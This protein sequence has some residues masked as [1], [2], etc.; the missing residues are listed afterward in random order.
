MSAKAL[1]K[2]ASSGPGRKSG[3]KLEL[4]RE[5]SLRF[6]S[7]LTGLVSSPSLEE[8]FS[9]KY[10]R[11]VLLSK[12]VDEK[13][14]PAS[15]LRR[16]AIVKWLGVEDRNRRTNLRL[17][18]T[19]PNFGF[20][21]G[22]ELL[23]RASR[24]I[25]RVIGREPPE[26]LLERGSF[27]G[28]ATTSVKRGLG[29]LASKFLGVRDVTPR[30]WKRLLPALSTFEG[31]AAYN[32][33]LD[34]PRYVR[35]NVLFTVPKSALIDRVACKEPDYNIFG[36]K[37]V[38]DYIRKR[39]RRRAGIDLNDQSRNRTLAR[40]GSRTGRLA[41]IDLS[42][43]SDSLTTGLV[44]LLLPHQW[45]TLLDDLRSPE[46][47]I[48]GEPHENEMF[49]SMGNGF[50]F[51]LE[52]LVFWA[53]AQEVRC[54]I[55]ATGPVSVYGDDIIVPTAC[56]GALIKVLSWVGF[57]ANLK[58][59]FLRGGFRESCGGHYYR[60]TD[61]TPFYLRR[62]VKDI[63][64]LIL[65]LNQLRRWL[66]L[67]GW[68]FAY[69][70]ERIVANCFVQFWRRWSRCV[71]AALH[72]GWDLSSRHQLVSAGPSRARLTRVPN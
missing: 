58:K 50:T 12:Y 59:T 1:A 54:A 36:Q 33:E 39:L 14:L 52:S 4:S 64:D 57:T 24:R 60:G 32:P 44:S 69:D 35:G 5:Q 62:P 8:D 6:H 43:A 9:L 18:E 3:R 34:K 28:G 68:D 2:F 42:S 61:V 51:E 41:T 56:A 71:P 55:G 72:G 11:E 25:E 67:T 13:T 19:D 53:L 37:A 10:L 26:D 23:R 30:A 66:I 49:S 63:S 15:E 65:T 38:G 46:T 45:F 31:W 20:R 16:L 17:F 29:T 27:S 47:F 22:H 21:Y 48:D 70:G 7:E 40:E